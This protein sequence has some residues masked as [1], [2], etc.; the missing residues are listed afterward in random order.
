MAISAK[1]H[2]FY[3]TTKRA[4]HVRDTADQIIAVS[5][6]VTKTAGT[7]TTVSSVGGFWAFLINHQQ[8]I[9]ILCAIVGAIITIIS[10]IVNAYAH[11][12]RDAR[13]QLEHSKRMAVMDY[14]LSLYD[15]RP[16]LRVFGDAE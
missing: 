5:A 10:A 16:R 4:D 1:S 2:V 12:R 9:L 14:Q 11:K 8:P 6:S 3:V 7:I 13:E 15:T